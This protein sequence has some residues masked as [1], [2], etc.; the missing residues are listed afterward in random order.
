MN[1]QQQSRTLIVNAQSL[2]LQL[3]SSSTCLQPEIPS[4]LMMKMT[5]NSLQFELSNSRFRSFRHWWTSSSSKIWPAMKHTE[6]TRR[7]ETN[8]IPKSPI[9]KF[10]NK[11]P[12]NRI[13]T[14]LNQE[15]RNRQLLP[16]EQLKPKISLL[17]WT[18]T[19]STNPRQNTT[20]PRRNWNA[21]G[22]K[23]SL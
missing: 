8:V 16:S 22:H 20:R 6:E 14:Q 5:L 21:T 1:Y 23:L 9:K 18:N 3:S 17:T 15:T 4:D 10:V 12:R 7:K 11:I 19:N 13:Y 2:V